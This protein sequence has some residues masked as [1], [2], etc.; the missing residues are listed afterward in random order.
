MRASF[1]P[2]ICEGPGFLGV[3]SID[4]A[5]QADAPVI[6]TSTAR[7]TVH[8]IPTDEEVMIARA[9]YDLLH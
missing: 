5:Q 6:S 3:G 8:V 7:V 2:A 1:A 9:A 4:R